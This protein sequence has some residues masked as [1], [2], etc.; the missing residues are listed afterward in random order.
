MPDAARA[1]PI[2]FYPRPP[3]GGRPL[4]CSP[5]KV[6]VII[7]IRALRGEGDAVLCYLPVEDLISIHALR[8]EGD[9]FSAKHGNHIK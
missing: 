3:W 9:V 8:G 5:A 7:S 2:D 4:R 6:S 1:A